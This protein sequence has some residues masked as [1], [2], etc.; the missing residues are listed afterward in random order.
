MMPGSYE[1]S[2]NYNHAGDGLGEC[3]AGMDRPR[4]R[5]GTAVSHAPVY[6]DEIALCVCVCVVCVCVWCVCVCVQ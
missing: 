6:A 4:L 1:L 3:N 5:L 2:P